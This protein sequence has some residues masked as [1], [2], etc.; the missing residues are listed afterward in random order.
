[1]LIKSPDSFYRLIESED[2]TSTQFMI[3]PNLL[4]GSPLRK[5]SSSN[6]G[7]L[8]LS[9]GDSAIVQE[10]QIAFDPLDIAF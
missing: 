2:L 10:L 3:D 7:N 1:V 5:G 8:T 9:N 6:R 4:S